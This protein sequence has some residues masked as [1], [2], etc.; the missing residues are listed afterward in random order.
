M[1]T[2]PVIILLLC[3]YR[4]QASLVVDLT[5]SSNEDKNTFL[6]FDQGIEINNPLTFCLRFNIKDSL[7]TNYIFSNKNDKLVLILSF[8][9][10]VG[11]ALINGVD[12]VFEIPKDNDV[13]PFH[14]HHICISS[15][16]DS[17]STVVD[18]KQWYRA[19]H[20][21]GSFEKTT[22]KRLDLG[23]T[24]DYWVYSD[25]INMRG[26][27]SELNIWSKSLSFIQMV[28]ITRNCGVEDPIPD[29]LNWS[30]LPK[31]IIIGSKYIENLENMCPQRNSTAPIYKVMPYLY[32]QD[33]AIHVC[34]LLNGELVFPNSLIEFQMWNG[35]LGRMKCRINV[36]NNFPL[37]IIIFFG[38]TCIR[39]PMCNF[40]GTYK[41]VIKWIMV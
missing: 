3:W 35:K 19:N 9:N 33:N 22:V 27:L 10:N 8:S 34:K 21:I 31:S 38:S 4:Y 14:W 26:L 32:D 40:H 17:Y 1:K 12:L 39:I 11:I 13:S 36:G 15:G 24:N 29:I 25:G 30:A 37:I 2:L 16:E 7:A 5:K 23:S 6:A 20:T 28:K 41:K 18:G